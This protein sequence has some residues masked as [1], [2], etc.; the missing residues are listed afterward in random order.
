MKIIVTSQNPVKI[1]AA[2]KIFQS[3][4]DDEVEVATVS[5]PSEVTDQ[6]RSEGETLLGAQNRVRNAIA[7]GFSGD[8]FVGIEGGIEVMNGR[9]FAFAWIVV[10][11]GKNVGE[12]RTAT[13]ELPHEVS[14]L[15]F[16]GLEL[17][18]AD[19]RVFQKENSKQKNGAVGLLTHDRLTRETL[20]AQA[21]TLAL[22]PFLNRKLY[23]LTD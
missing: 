4:F 17:G 23:D 8:Y 6:P 18:D 9:M 14:R 22:I 1:N 10:S 21:M 19:D 16:Q 2:V 7:T 3:C 20:Y 12:A 15:I 5:V 13:F 11:D